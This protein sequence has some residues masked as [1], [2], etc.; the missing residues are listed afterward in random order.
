MEFMAN[1]NPIEVLAVDDEPAVALAI[2]SALEF[3]G[4]SVL[5]VPSGAIAL[6]RVQAEP[7][8]FGIVLSDH[9]MPGVSGIDLVKGLRAIAYPGRIVILSGFISGEVEVQYQALGVDQIL[10]KPFNIV[11]LRDALDQALHASATRP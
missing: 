10:A 8:R 6:Q 1:T 11:R 2:K 5:T 3:C 9:N 4:Y 7:L